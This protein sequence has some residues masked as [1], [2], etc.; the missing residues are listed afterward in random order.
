MKREV[1]KWRR[2]WLGRNLGDSLFG[3]SSALLRLGSTSRL[4][5]KTG[6]EKAQ[7]LRWVPTRPSKAKCSEIPWDRVTVLI[8]NRL[9]NCIH[10]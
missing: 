1:G 3:D 7:I 6:F 5:K 8:K 4:G 2:G 9:C 10:R